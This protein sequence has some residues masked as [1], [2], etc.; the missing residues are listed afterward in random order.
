MTLLLDEI[1]F[2]MDYC[3]YSVLWPTSPLYSYSWHALCFYP[4]FISINLEKT[5]DVNV[6]I[7]GCR[8]CWTAVLY[9]DGE[10]HYHNLNLSSFS[11]LFL[12]DIECLGYNLISGRFCL[13][14]LEPVKVIESISLCLQLHPLSPA[15]TAPG[16]SNLKQYLNKL[17]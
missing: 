3:Y 8:L 9:S 5:I 4:L 17:W 12:L 1:L 11:Q 2:L 13:A 6:I 14:Q 10:E 7:K 16:F 15:R